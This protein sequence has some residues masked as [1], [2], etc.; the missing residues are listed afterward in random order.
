M[1]CRVHD[2]VLLPLLLASCGCS[3]TQAVDIST[4]AHEGALR[5]EVVREI[6]SADQ[7]TSA[8]PPLARALHRG[9]VIR[10][11]HDFGVIRPESTVQHRFAVENTSAQEWTIAA[12]SRSCV[13]AVAT[14]TATVL[15]PGATEEFEVVYRAG[16]KSTDFEQAVQVQFA[17]PEPPEVIFRVFGRIRQ[18]VTVVPADIQFGPIPPHAQASVWLELGNHSGVAWSAIRLRDHPSWLE[19]AEAPVRAWGP[20]AAHSADA[21]ERWRVEVI[22]RSG[23]LTAVSHREE[24][25]W[26]AVAVSGT[27]V[28]RVPVELRVEAPYRVLPTQLFL[29][30]I[31][32]GEVVAKQVVFTF[33]KSDA[34]PDHLDQSTISHDLPQDLRFDWRRISPT[35]WALRIKFLA[36]GPGAP[37]AGTLIVQPADS[38]QPIAKLPVN[39]WVKSAVFSTGTEP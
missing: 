36:T 24:M 33:P 38:R 4:S 30:N 3:A 19:V 37:T 35:A 34:C 29:G 26:E 32:A 18:P 2:G 15:K 7:A 13:C 11:E 20:D 27:F 28:A 23:D 39:L 22:A 8:A 17:E 25:T 6:V 16:A 5:S 12:I 1:G 10:L 9:K 31:T 21:M 14:T